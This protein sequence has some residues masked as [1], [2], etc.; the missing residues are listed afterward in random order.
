MEPFKTVPV[1]AAPATTASAPAVVAPAVQTAAAKAA[2]AAA[3]AVPASAAPSTALALA[4]A[5]QPTSSGGALSGLGSWFGG[6]KSAAAPAASPAPLASA[7]EAKPFYKR[8]LGL[9]SDEQSVPVP[10]EATTGPAPAKVPLPP[11]RQATNGDRQ[12][13]SMAIDPALSVESR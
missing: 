7:P 8:W 3:A 13:L 11:K 6:S 2:P 4:P 10:V 5:Q 9:G 12:K 1:Q